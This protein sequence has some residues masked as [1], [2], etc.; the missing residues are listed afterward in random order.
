MPQLTN[1]MNQMNIGGNFPPPPLAGAPPGSYSQPN[2][3][4]PP[5]PPMS[6]PSVGQGMP[7]MPP[8]SSP[9]MGQPMPPMP[10]APS[11]APTSAQQSRR[12]DPDHMPSPIQVIEDDKSK[13]SGP[14]PTG[15]RGS[16]PPLVTT[17]FVAVDQGNCSPRFIRSTMYN[18]PSQPDLI[19]QC[20]I[21]IALSIS[22]FA[23][24]HPDEVPPPLVDLGEMGPVRCKRCK[25]YM[26]P[27]MQFIDGGRRFVC[28]FC[29][30]STD[31]PENYFAHLDHTGYRVDVNS[32]P[33]LCLGTYEFVAPKEYCKN[34]VLPKPPAYLFMIDVSY[35]SVQNGFVQ[36]ICQHLKERV[37]PNLPIEAGKD[38]SDIRV[39]FVTYDKAVHFYNVK[40][41]LA[42]PQMMVVPDVDEMFMPLLDGF[43]VKPSEAEEVI[44]NLMLQIP[45]MFG[46]TRETE[47]VLG[48]II[49]AGA[50]ALK[51][52]GRP[53]KVF[54]FHSTLPL[55]EAPGKLKNRDDRKLLGTEKEKTIL[56][57]QSDFYKKLAEQC[58]VQGCC[59]DLFLF[60]NAYVDVATI[61]DICK[62]TGGSLFRY[63]YFQ[64]ETDGERFLEDLAMEVGRPIG[65]DAIMRVRTSTGIRATD[66]WGSFYMSNTTDVEFAAVDC[67]KAV[68]VEIKYDDKL[69]E[70][71]GAFVQAALLYT[72]VGGQRRLRIHN[73]AFETCSQLA[74]VYRS[75]DTD[76]LIN[77]LGKMSLSLLTQKNIA[78]IREDTSA[79]VAQIL[80]CYRKNCAQPSSAGQL[81]LPE[82]MKLLPVYINCLLKCDALA[83]GQEITVDDRSWL[84]LTLLSMSVE[85]S[86]PFFY[87]TV[88]PVHDL[89]SLAEDQVAPVAVR[90]S[91]ER[92]ADNGAYLVEN[93]ISLFLYIGLQV[94][95]GWIKDIFDVDSLQQVDVEKCRISLL[96]NENSDRLNTLIGHIRQTRG[97]HMRLHIVRRNDPKM[98]QW[99]RHYLV[100][101][102]GSFNQTPSYVDYLC[103][104]H[105]EIRQ[106]LS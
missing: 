7:P 88:Y 76:T 77:C 91:I 100:E 34:N 38:E 24:L 25:A 85:S 99:F 47:I 64:A 67:D 39:G 82:C 16:V 2:P 26:C 48:P 54:V 42:Q 4:M 51:A 30:A 10:P 17:D 84:M 18:I 89:L 22:P 57:A 35:N 95:A 86:V 37:L 23:R 52:D 6:S 8:M 70:E 61:G 90:A 98:E 12:L 53:G 97:R 68:S 96:E 92:L 33:E 79:Q 71:G 102:K 13:C 49:Q 105:K 5:M 104:I 73:L 78:K 75:C 87:P 19:K 101:D 40:E 36:L 65:F 11:P 74:D 31:V 45:E 60:P 80:S 9:P 103:Q 46:R 106:L 62:Y 32:R 81:I 15:Q 27:Y 3:M 66:F 83:G 43:F 50:E 93:G 28:N 72:T 69:P 21:P 14:W 29:E 20:H 56:A 59:V 55:H 58:V 94:D 1:Q 44:D 63:N 41:T